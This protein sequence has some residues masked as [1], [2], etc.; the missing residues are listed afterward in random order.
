MVQR[1]REPVTVKDVWIS[2]KGAAG[3]RD[4]DDDIELITE[5]KLFID[6]GRYLIEY[7]ESQMTGMFGTKTSMSIEDGNVTVVR[8]GR[9]NSNFLFTKGKRQDSMYET[10]DGSFKVSIFTSNVDIDFGDSGGIVKVEYQVDFMNDLGK[11]YI[12]M[13]VREVKH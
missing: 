13:F 3:K 6:N 2:I 9:I 5:G 10:E 7:D 8:Q 4:P 1:S 11:N 12:H